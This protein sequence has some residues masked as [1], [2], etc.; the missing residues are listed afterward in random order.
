MGMR[1]CILIL[2]LL[3]LTGCPST[4]QPY[5]PV[6][7]QSPS[8]LADTVSATLQALLRLHNEQRELKGRQG[9][10]LDPYLCEYAQHHAEWMANHN[11]LQHSNISKLMGKYYAAGENIAW[12]QSNEKEVVVAW[13][14]STGH[15][16]N[17]LSR[18]FTHVGFGVAFNKNGE[19]YWCACFGG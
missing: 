19:P 9:L 12:N 1:I 7:W 13:M 14:N 18:T 11:N 3:C 15:R 8:T 10:T 6:D 5:H 4:Q 16:E 17:I 2:M